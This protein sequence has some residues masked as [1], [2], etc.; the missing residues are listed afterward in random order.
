MTDPNI[1]AALAIAQSYTD[2]SG[3]VQLSPPQIGKLVRAVLSLAAELETLRR[4][5]VTELTTDNCMHNI[6]IDPDTGECATCG[7]V[8][9]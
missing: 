5:H 3:R 7:T 4:A 1:S 2:Q 6:E 9:P 8:L